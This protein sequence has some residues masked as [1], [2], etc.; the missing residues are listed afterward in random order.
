MSDTFTKRI[1]L[2]RGAFEKRHDDPA[3]DFGIGCTI[4]EFALIGPDG[5]ISFECSTGWHLPHVAER[6]RRRDFSDATSHPLEPCGY[7]VVI[8]SPHVLSEY[9][10][11]P[12]TDACELIGGPCWTDRAFRAGDDFMAAVIAEG[13]TGL[14]RL[15]EEWYTH[16]LAP[17]EATT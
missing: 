9:S 11:T 3:L 15:A 7:A 10:P 14:W 17:Q 6:F 16:H 2:P 5:A 1:R 12:D 4:M 8:H 13:E